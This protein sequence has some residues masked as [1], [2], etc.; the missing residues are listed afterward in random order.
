MWLANI[1]SWCIYVNIDVASLEALLTKRESILIALDAQRFGQLR[2]SA[3]EYGHLALLLCLQL[4]E[5]L[6]PVGSPCIGACLEARYQITL[7]L[8]RNREE[9]V[10][11]EWELVMASLVYLLVQQIQCQLQP[12][13]LH[14][15][16]L[17][18]AGDVHVHVQ[19]A[20]VDDKEDYA[21]R[22]LC[23]DVEKFKLQLTAPWRRPA[24]PVRSPAAT[25]D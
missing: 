20:E 14:V 9:E 18:C 8:E 2:W 3:I 7:A 15:R 4:L 11:E 19:E 24:R 6:V 16:A 1:E 12:H 25:A 23:I 22:G 13:S 21:C 17:Q 10:S 5:Y